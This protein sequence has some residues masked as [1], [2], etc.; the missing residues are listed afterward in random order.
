MSPVNWTTAHIPLSSGMNTGTDPRA[1]QPPAL[2]VCRDAEFDETL[3]LQTRPPFAP[4]LDSASNTIANIR[5]LAIYNDELLAFTKDGLWSYAERDGLWIQRATYLAAKIEERAVF[6]N[7]SEQVQ[8]DRAEVDNVVLFAWVESGAGLY[9]AALDKDTSAVIYGPTLIGSGYT[10][11]RVVAMG[12]HFQFLYADVA[13]N[14]LWSVGVSPDNLADATV[15]LDKTAVLDTV[16]NDYYDVVK[17]SA[18]ATVA[19]A[20]RDTTTSYTIA[21]VT[22]SLGDTSPTV[23]ATTKARTCDGPIAVSFAPNGTHVQVIRADGTNIEGDYLSLAGP[24]TDVAVDQAVGTAAGTVNQIA[25]AHRSVTNSSQYRCYAFWSSAETSGASSFL[26]KTN[27]VDTGGSLGTEATFVRRLGVASR[28]FDHDGRVYVW[29]A[30]AGE[31]SFSGGNVTDFRAQLQNTYFL[32]RDDAFLTAK[33]ATF[34]AGG[35]SQA[36][37]HLPGVQSLGSNRYAWCGL[38]RRVI[39]LS[40]KHTGYSDRGPREV[41]VEFDS[42]EARRS[43]QMGQTLYVTGGEIMAYD[44]TQLVEAGFHLFPHYFGALEA[45]DAEADGTI[46]DGTYAMKL[47]WAWENARGELDRSTTATH[48]SVEI[49]AAPSAKINI[50]SGI[51]LYVTHK[52]TKPPAVEVWRTLKD[53]TSEAPFYL[54]TSKDPT[55]LTN[56]NRYIPNDPT[57]TALPTYNDELSDADLAKRE[58]NPENGGLLEN[59]SPPP[60]TV[61][62]STQDRVFLAGIAGDPHRVWYSKLRGEGEVAA[63]HDALTIDLP[64][65]GGPIT[66]LAFLND[67]LIVFKATAIYALA[68]DG[69]DNAGGGQNYGPA[70]LLSR[71]CGAQTAD[72]V[73]LVPQGL[74]FHSRK[75]WYVLNHGWSPTYI[76]EPVSEFDGDTFTSVHVLES[77][78]EVRC[79]STSRVLVWDYSVNQWSE[80]TIA[81]ALHSVLWDGDEVYAVDDG[82]TVRVEDPEFSYDHGIDIE[83]PW[84]KVAEL[85]GFAR[86]RWLMV[87]GEY[88]SAHRLRVRVA[89]DYLQTDDGV[90]FFDDQEWTVSPTTVGGPLQLRHGPSIQKCE[91]IKVRLSTFHGGGHELDAST[92]GLWKLDETAAATYA[93]F[94]D[95]TANVKHLTAMPTADP[96]R[97]V[98]G[99]SPI[100]TRRARW[101]DGSTQYAISSAADTALNTFLVASSY[102]VIA[103]VRP[104]DNGGMRRYIFAYGQSGDT[105]EDTNISGSVFI[106]GTGLIGSLRESGAGGTNNEVIQVAGTP[107]PNG[108]WSTVAVTFSGTTTRVYYWNSAGV[109]G[110][111]DTLTQALAT[112]GGSAASR[113]YIGQST[114]ATSFFKGSMRG[115]T[116]ISGVLS[117]SQLEALV[118]RSN[119]DSDATTAYRYYECNETPDAID[120]GPLGQHLRLYADGTGARAVALSTTPTTDTTLCGDSGVSRVL[121]GTRELDSHLA[122]PTTATVRTAMLADFTLEAWIRPDAITDVTR[123]L[124]VFGDPEPETQA[125]NHIGVQISSTGN[126]FTTME[127]GAGADASGQYSVASGLVAG[128]RAHVAFV[129]YVSAGSAFV[130]FY[131]NGL[132]VGASGALTNLDGAT[133]GFL[134]LLAGPSEDGWKGSIDDIR[135]S[136]VRRTAAEILASYTNAPVGPCLKLT[137][138]ALEYGVKRGL[139]RHLPAAQKQ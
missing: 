127:S 24:F 137:G 86:T 4:I 93:Q 7:T 76:G 85:Q 66:A 88:R 75:G 15:S 12:D 92:I 134:R 65:D 22:S 21:T 6:I 91:A 105:G 116:I 20:R 36:T 111:Q 68:G 35:F 80:W 49:T 3:G 30:F 77:K 62:T 56:P 108:E 90:T 135:L 51:P 117:L 18:T 59:L 71:D 73:A 124:F 37:G 72:T 47:T 48:G 110:L 8:A 64:P 29:T 114:A 83:T 69:F 41:V 103:R 106:G 13:N 27:W 102:T 52:T 131:V 79:Y 95:G 26:S 84:I 39:P 96:P 81:D 74:I 40:I 139:Y 44:G 67:T 138:L 60:A 25:A 14:T 112:G 94:V 31:S 136:S 122:H 63:F 128:E 120:E 58:T 19:V 2:A 55:S 45:A 97:V 34:K 107:V 42:N 23:A 28:A 87:L 126:L 16:F 133:N 104:E 57:A 9:I 11:P 125:D 113:M 70:R 5:R 101:F 1:L 50:A 129:K 32:Y 10:R 123:G 121:A 132:L 46:E 89:R 98:G 33:A 99:P 61:V 115:L 118:A 109:G 100:S 82:E 119:W 38:E 43:V 17:I 54:T 53:P 130:E 78:H